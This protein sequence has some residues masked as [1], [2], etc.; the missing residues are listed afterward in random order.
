MEIIKVNYQL[1]CAISPI[2]VC[3]CDMFVAVGLQIGFI[4]YDTTSYSFYCD[5]ICCVVSLRKEDHIL[6]TRTFIWLQYH[7]YMMIPLIL[8]SNPYIFAF[9]LT[10]HGTHAGSK[11][12]CWACNKMVIFLLQYDVY[13]YAFMYCF[14]Q[15]LGLLTDGKTINYKE[16]LFEIQKV[17]KNDAMN[18]I[19]EFRSKHEVLSKH[20]PAEWT[21]EIKINSPLVVNVSAKGVTQEDAE[22]TAAALM[23]MKLRVSLTSVVL[24]LVSGSTVL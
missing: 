6:H 16:T 22:Q 1:G 24:H 13:Y 9:C 11:H 2:I 23:I 4:K 17:F 10:H 14:L 18:Q 8:G 15:H 19:I 20:S 5:L 12:F 7:Y 3:C 21:T